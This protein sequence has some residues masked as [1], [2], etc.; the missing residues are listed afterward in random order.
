MYDDASLHEVLNSLVRDEQEAS[1]DVQARSVVRWDEGKRANE[2]E[3]CVREKKWRE[4][5]EPLNVRAGGRV[6]QVM[7]S[8]EAMTGETRPNR[9]LNQDDRDGW[10]DLMGKSRI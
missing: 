1:D 9:E 7:K 3:K 8:D 4:L 10:R 6:R 2:E 5:M